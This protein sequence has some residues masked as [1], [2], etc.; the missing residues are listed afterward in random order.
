MQQECRKTG[1][2]QS[3]PSSPVRFPGPHTC[4]HA[5]VRSRER[6]RSSIPY[7][8]FRSPF[9]VFD[10]WFWLSVV[11]HSRASVL[12]L[13]L[14]FGRGGS[15][16]YVIFTR[17]RGVWGILG[18][19]FSCLVSGVFPVGR[20]FLGLG[21]VI[22]VFGVLARGRC[23]RARWQSS[24]F[25]FRRSRAYRADW[26]RSRSLARWPAWTRSRVRVRVRVRDA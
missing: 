10:L 13:I 22:F 11:S 19:V 2:E 1:I 4:V 8:V 12:I 7:S 23:S 16:P 25:R 15:P 6:M 20:V 21:F 5:C 24:R 9:P 14:I 18:L 3:T 17:A 26:P